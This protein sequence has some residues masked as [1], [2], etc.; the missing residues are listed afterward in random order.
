MAYRKASQEAY[1]ALDEAKGTPMRQRHRRRVISRNAFNIY[2]YRLRRLG[3]I[4]YIRDKKGEI[5]Q[6]PGHRLQGK[7]AMEAAELHPRLYFRLT[8]EGAS[9]D[10]TNI[11]RSYE[12]L[13]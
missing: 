13:Y 3:W 1:E 11:Q 4:E 7:V 5:L 6:E 12:D 8:P 10:W 9:N 2:L